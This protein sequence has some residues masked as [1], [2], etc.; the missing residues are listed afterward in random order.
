M[1]YKCKVCGQRFA[2]RWSWQQHEKGH[3]GLKPYLC[4]VCGKSFTQACT[5]RGHQK[6]HEREEEAAT[7]T[8]SGGAASLSSSVVAGTAVNR[9]RKSSAVKKRATASA[10]VPAE[11]ASNRRDVDSLQHIGVESLSPQPPSL[12]QAHFVVSAEHQ[13]QLVADRDGSLTSSGLLFP[14][15][16]TSEAQAMLPPIEYANIIP[17]PPPPHPVIPFIPA[18]RRYHHMTTPQQQNLYGH[19]TNG[20]FENPYM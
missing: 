15:R 17:H 1:Q 4:N 20:R 5:L 11:D 12:P 3:L 14:Y 2:Y 9:R 16:M 10:S 13:T 19:Y 6:T 7:G 8:F 18:D